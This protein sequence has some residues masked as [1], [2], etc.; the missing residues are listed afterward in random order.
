[1]T[2]TKNF[3]KNSSYLGTTND[4]VS[5][6]VQGGQLGYGFKAGAFDAATPLVFSPAVICVLATPTM[7]DDMPDD[8]EGVLRQTVKSMF[9]CHAKSVSGIEISYTVDTGEQ[10]IGHDGQNL[11]VPLQTKRQAVT[12]S[13]TYP[14]ITGNLVWNLHRRWVWDMSDPD[15][16]TGL[17][18]M[19]ATPNPYTMSTYSVTFAA[20][21]YDPTM[22]PSRII[23]CAIYTNVWPTT[24]T[25]LGMQ[26]E[27]GTSSVKERAITY[28][29][30]IV[31]NDR[32]RDLGISLAEQLALRSE[33]YKT[34]SPN[35]EQISPL[36]NSREG[37]RG[38]IDD[39]TLANTG[40]DSWN[41]KE[42]NA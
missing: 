6:L 8:P 24:T 33:T 3:L 4:L 26:R 7:W 9:E 13:F 1:M 38:I 10:P 14:E 42:P 35:T 29:G 5:N 27:I 37:D 32:T 12:P 30:Y 36:I 20:I 21:Q 19:G 34:A 31:H 18:H 40:G 25:E 28:A 11:Q 22:L 15:T 39:P 17:E 16:N 2:E 41:K 23:D